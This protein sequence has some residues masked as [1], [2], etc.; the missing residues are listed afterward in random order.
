VIDDSGNELAA[1]PAVRLGAT[2]AARPL[3]HH[4]LRAA[5]DQCRS[6]RESGIELSVAVN[7]SVR[8]VVDLDLPAA[9][10]AELDR[11]GLPPQALGIEVTETM[12]ELDPNRTIEVLAR[13]HELGVRI[14]LDDFGTGYSSLSYLQRMPVDE[15]KIDR[16]F[17]ATWPEARRTPASSRTP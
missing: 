9:I 14:S 15:L 7:L 8:D 5:L 4:V 13:L 11:C 1:R 12:L 3:M 2:A 17:I 16:S 6:W 10:A